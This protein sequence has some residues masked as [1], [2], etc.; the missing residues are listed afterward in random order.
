MQPETEQPEGGE[1]GTRSSRDQRGEV[2]DAL[3]KVIF[4]PLAGLAYP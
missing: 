4:N 2:S 3:R 1:I